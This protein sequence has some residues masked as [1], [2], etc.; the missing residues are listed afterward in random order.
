MGGFHV[1]LENPPKSPFFK[2]GLFQSLLKPTIL[3]LN[4]L[5]RVALKLSFSKKEIKRKLSL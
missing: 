3:K 2:G 5:V 1:T 4:F